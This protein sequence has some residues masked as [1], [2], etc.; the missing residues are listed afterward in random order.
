MKKTLL[1]GEEITI[2]VRYVL[3]ACVFGLVMTT[4]EY[5]KNKNKIAAP[6]WCEAAC[7][8]DGGVRSYYPLGHDVLVHTSCADGM[9]YGKDAKCETHG[10]IKNRVVIGL[11]KQECFCNSGGVV[12]KSVGDD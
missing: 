6:E 5:E 8:N 12:E 10:G 1:T 9:W 11:Q 7:K 4:Y 2:I 3:G